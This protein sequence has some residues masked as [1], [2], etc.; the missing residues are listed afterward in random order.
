MGEKSQI[1][2]WPYMI[3]TKYIF[4]LTLL[5]T[6]STSIAADEKDPHCV[7]FGTLEETV[8]RISMH[9]LIARP[10]RYDGKLVQLTGYLADGPA[11]LLFVGEDAWSTSRTIDSVALKVEADSVKRQI[12]QLGRTYA[13]V[14]GRFRSK[15]S[16]LSG[17]SSEPISG[18]IQ[19]Q[20]VGRP[21]APW[22]YAE[23]VPSL[24]K[25]SN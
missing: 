22:G 10:E 11:P 4:V 16:F 1:N 8:C 9:A 24:L 2:R 6:C 20:E 5:I 17:A 23:P 25:S 12:N 14:L 21:I 7:A 15:D 19:V 18:S 3:T 13:V